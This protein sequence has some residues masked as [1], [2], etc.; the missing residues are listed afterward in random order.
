MQQNKLYVGNL[1]YSVGETQLKD[2]FAPYGEINEV[3]LIEDRETG[4]SKGFAF[5]TFA[6]SEAAEKALEQDGKEYDGRPLK[7]NAAQERDRGGKSGGFGGEK[8]GGFG[9]DKRGG[10]GGNK[11]GGGFGGDKRGGRDDRH[12]R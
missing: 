4:R 8:R 2:L 3:T 12:R 11:R 5:I 10:F 7:V 9:G 6:T 1:S